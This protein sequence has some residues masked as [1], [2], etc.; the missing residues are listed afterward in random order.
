[1]HEEAHP[2]SA[3]WHAAERLV[4][5]WGG[6]LRGREF[7][8]FMK[9]WRPQRG[10]THKARQRFLYLI[11]QD[12]TGLICFPGPT[13]CNRSP[14]III[15]GSK[16]SKMKRSRAYEA[17]KRAPKHRKPLSTTIAVNNWKTKGNNAPLQTNHWKTKETMPQHRFKDF[18]MVGHGFFDL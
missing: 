1:M 9:N 4:G 15:F 5:S 7:V 16:A 8:I 3:G 10:R 13:I 14:R 12:R 18:S 17:S 2:K 11:H 6:W